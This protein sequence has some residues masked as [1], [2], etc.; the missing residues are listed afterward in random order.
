MKAWKQSGI[1]EKL[2][3]YCT[4][5]DKVRVLKVTII[6]VLLARQ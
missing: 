5:I 2:A 3:D 6:E 4:L 1:A